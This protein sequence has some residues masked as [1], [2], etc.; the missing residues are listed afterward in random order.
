MVGGQE[1][2]L[3]PVEEIER[4][5][6][7]DE[8]NVP[9]EETVV[10]SLLTWVGHDAAT[11]ERHLPRLLSHVRLPLLR[12]Q[13]SSNCAVRGRFVME[14]LLRVPLQRIHRNADKL[15]LI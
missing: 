2:L 11:R 7:S 10:T 14:S 8:V 3:L 6:V 5:L 12:P 13:V 4:L 1:F 9:D 15:H